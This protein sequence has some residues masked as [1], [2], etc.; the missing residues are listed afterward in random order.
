MF[1]E[2]CLIKEKFFC[3]INNK[4]EFVMCL[5]ADIKSVRLIA[6]NKH[7]ID[8]KPVAMLFVY[9]DSLSW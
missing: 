5:G 7:T 4:H 8:L 3:I 1:T 9:I 6:V 2:R